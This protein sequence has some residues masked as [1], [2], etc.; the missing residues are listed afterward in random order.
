MFSF[1]FS[2]FSPKTICQEYK[3]RTNVW[4]QLKGR[5]NVGPDMDPNSLQRLLAGDTS[6]GMVKLCALISRMSESYLSWGTSYIQQPLVERLSTN[7]CT[8]YPSRLIIKGIYKAAPPFLPIV[9]KIEIQ[10]LFKENTDRLVSKD[11]CFSCKYTG[12]AFSPLTMREMLQFYTGF[13]SC[14]L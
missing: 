11:A 8:R 5:Q 14:I 2:F 12:F 3:R 1:N 9:S 13:T 7:E 6:R 10:K 4:I